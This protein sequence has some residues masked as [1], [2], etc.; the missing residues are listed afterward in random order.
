M[1]W[2]LDTTV[3]L[4]FGRLEALWVIQQGLTDPKTVVDEVVAELRRPP[5]AVNQLHAA[6]TDGWLRR[7]VLSTDAELEAHAAL[8]QQRPR[9]GAGEAA[10]L[11]TCIAN[12]WALASDDQD[13]RRVAT[14]RTVPVTGTIGILLRAIRRE[15]LGVAPAE[16]LLQLMIE[17]GYRSP[18]THLADLLDRR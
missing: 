7:H 9:L 14:T 2:V 15:V 8:H 5:V 18:V 4:Y 16:E 1:T 12:G 13:A 6:M 3:V 11:A 17:A 10:S